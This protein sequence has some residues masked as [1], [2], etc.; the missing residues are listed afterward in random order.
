M[1]LITQ[2]TAAKIYQCYRELSTAEKLLLDMEEV[3]KK[4]RHD[5]FEQNLRDAFGHMRPLQ[6][7]IPSGENSH[8]LFDVSPDLAGS[9]IRAHIAHKKAELIEIN[10]QAHIE[11]LLTGE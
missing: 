7:G 5:P 1:G 8:R 4:N 3:R 6:L 11:L 2:D 9:V 10:E